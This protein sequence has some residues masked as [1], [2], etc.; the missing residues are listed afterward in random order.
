MGPCREEQVLAGGKADASL[1]VLAAAAAAACWG[2]PV[3]LS[4]CGICCV[5]RC[6]GSGR[7]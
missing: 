4:D 1:E 7:L 3:Q 2:G 6:Q 5:G